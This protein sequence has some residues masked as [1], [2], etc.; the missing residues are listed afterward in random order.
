MVN[1]DWVAPWYPYRFEDEPV[2]E[3]ALHVL[4]EMAYTW[5]DPRSETGLPEARTMVFMESFIEVREAFRRHQKDPP[6]AV[7]TV[8]TSKRRVR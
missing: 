3:A 2:T 5:I 6:D 1:T 7:V 8:R 4:A